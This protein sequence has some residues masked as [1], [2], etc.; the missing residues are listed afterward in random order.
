MSTLEKVSDSILRKRLSEL[1]DLDDWTNKCATCGRP[2]FLYKGFCTR[3][4]KD[5][6]EDLV[7][8]WTEYKKR[9]RSHMRWTKYDRANEREKD[10]PLEGLKKLMFDIS[11][12]NTKNK[13]TVVSSLKTD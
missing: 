3:E 7:Q 5:S 4:G 11:Y 12:Q 2:D 6:P 1:I 13:E 8:I 9:I 10:S